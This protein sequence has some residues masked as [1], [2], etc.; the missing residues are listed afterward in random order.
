MK[1]LFSLFLLMG[2]SACQTTVVHK[3]DPAPLFADKLFPTFETQIIETETQVFELDEEMRQFVQK[4]MSLRHS[5]RSPVEALIA[6]IFGRAELN[7]LYIN[8]ANTSARETFHNQ[9]ANC[10]SL[11]IMT[12]ALAKHAN[13]NARFYEVQVPELWTVRNGRSFLNG[14]VNLRLSHS[15]RNEDLIVFNRVSSLEVDF[16]RRVGRLKLK[17]EPITQQRVLAMFYNNKGADALALNN[18][19]RAYAY[20]RQ[21]LLLEPEF[22]SAW[23]NLG[24]LYRHVSEL[25]L[26]EKAYEVAVLLSPDNSSARENM[27]YLYSL[28]GREEQANGIL[29]SLEKKRRR[30]PYYQYL[31]GEQQYEKRN[32][33]QAVKHFR[34]AIQM[35]GDKHEFYFALA[36]AYYQSGDISHS[37]L[38]LQKA[39]ELADNESVARKYQSKLDTLSR[40]S[41]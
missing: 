37:Q 2:L 4:Q 19:D 12:F 10:L 34:K 41:G 1:V 31:L 27:A 11:S 15:V 36:R 21:A 3:I 28:T 20:F 14:H 35:R 33:M 24:V 5:E 9:A 38:F 22:D 16:D 30:N 25:E 8:N 40:R 18:Q 29:R 7:L 39:K 26:A 23:V 13:F 17:S 6:G 32:W